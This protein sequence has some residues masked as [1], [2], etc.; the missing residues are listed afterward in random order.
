MSELQSS[1][2]A[3]GE[4]S[5]RLTG[6]QM[7]SMAFVAIALVIDDKQGGRHQWD[8]SLLDYLQ[9]TEVGIFAAVPTYLPVV[10]S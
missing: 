8:M 4:H 10:H 6:K 5:T 3:F 9:T 1:I 2:S 7:F